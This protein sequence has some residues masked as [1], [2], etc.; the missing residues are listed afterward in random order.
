MEGCLRERERE[1]E[2]KR[3]RKK[4]V[5]NMKKVN[6]IKKKNM[7]KERR[8]W[9][10][11]FVLIQILRVEKF[12]GSEYPFNFLFASS[13]FFFSPY[14][15]QLIYH[16]FLITL[17]SFSLIHCHVCYFMFFFFFFFFLFP[18]FFFPVMSSFYSLM[19]FYCVPFLI[20]K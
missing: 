6:V 2:R 8:K 9:G 10:N 14:W 12:F 13:R 3:E 4:K 16:L 11:N 18:H 19:L 7:D 17:L 5:K 1:R 20:Y 15:D